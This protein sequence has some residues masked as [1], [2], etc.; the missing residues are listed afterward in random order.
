MRW[1]QTG[2]ILVL[3]LAACATTKTPVTTGPSEGPSQAWRAGLEA[4]IDA[5]LVALE[6]RFPGRV[7]TSRM[8]YTGLSQGAIM[9]VSIV[10]GNAERFPY[11][12]LIEGGHDDW[13]DRRVR[14]FRRDGGQRVILACGGRRCNRRAEEAQERFEA[15]SVDVRVFYAAEAG[16]SFAIN[17]RTELRPE[18]DWLIAEDPRWVPTPEPAAE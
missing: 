16:H 11:A 5:G 7:D 3:G 13:S 17:R 15:Q 9:G 4:E 8:V 6:A 14:A 12:V 18:F 10:S 1:Q 2:L